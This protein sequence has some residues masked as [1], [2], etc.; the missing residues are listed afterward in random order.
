M[1][2]Q[3]TVLISA[4]RSCWNMNPVAFIERL[5]ECVSTVLKQTTKGGKRKVRA[6]ITRYD[7]KQNLKR[8]GLLRPHANR[9]GRH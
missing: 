3:M 8:L 9:K 7:L 4:D 6:F 1:N 2:V 5:E